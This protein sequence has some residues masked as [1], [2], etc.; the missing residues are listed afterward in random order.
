MF[1]TRPRTAR[2]AGYRGAQRGLTSTASTASR[3]SS[4]AVTRSRTAATWA[5]SPKRLHGS[6]SVHVVFAGLAGARNGD[7]RVE[8]LQRRRRAS[9]ERTRLRDA[10]P[11]RTLAPCHRDHARRRKRPLCLHA[12]SQRISSARDGQGHPLSYGLGVRLGQPRLL[13]DSPRGRDTV[14]LTSPAQ[15]AQA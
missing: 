6:G 12:G 3:A 7:C 4:A 11:P 2:S 14:A 13:Y 1:R 9:S 5:Q 10:R 8:K 15:S